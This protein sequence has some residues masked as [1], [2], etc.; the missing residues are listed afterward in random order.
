[1]IGKILFLSAVASGLL[2]AQD[3]EPNS[4]DATPQPGTGVP[5]APPSK[6]S[7]PLTNL[8]PANSPR[9]P[10]FKPPKEIVSN[11]FFIEP[12]VPP[13]EDEARNPVLSTAAPKEQDQPLLKLMPRRRNP[14]AAAAPSLIRPFSGSSS[15]SGTQARE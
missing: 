3:A 1:M 6:C 9:M 4:R 15:S 12:P 13:C 11:R 5:A 8:L 10:M 7:I 2:T 14:P